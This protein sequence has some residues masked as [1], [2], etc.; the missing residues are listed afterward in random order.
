MSVVLQSGLS[1][2][3][4]SEGLLTES[5]DPIL[6]ETGAPILTETRSDAPLCNPR[7][8]HARN[9]LSGTVTA[10]GT[11]AGYFAA[12]PDNT[13]TYEFWKPDAMPATWEIDV[14]AGDA[15]YCCIAA[16][17]LGT[18]G[19]SVTAQSWDGAAWAD[20]VDVT[21]AD[22]S[23]IMMLFA[24]VSSTKFRIRITGDVA[25]EIGVIKFGMAL[26]F[27]WHVFSGHTPVSLGRQTVLRDNLSETGEFLGRTKLRTRLETA[28]SWDR[29]RRPWVYAN[30]PDLQRALEEEPF[31]IAFRPATFP[32]VAFAQVDEVPVPQLTGNSDYMAVEMAVRARGYD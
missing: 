16:H 24:P 25:P 22:D 20:I 28:L 15:D 3:T 21:P 31:F 29:L 2:T 17:T 11:A 12:A 32:D 30:W 19:A 9:W 27:P 13:L 8:A 10:S 14:G 18:D 26:Q 23:P 1:A 4:A 5:G 7:M 6:T